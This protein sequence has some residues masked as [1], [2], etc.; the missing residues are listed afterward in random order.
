MS[1][2]VEDKINKFL[3]DDDAKEYRFAP[4]DQIHR[5][6]MY[7]KDSVTETVG[8]IISALFFF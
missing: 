5:S 8:E 7:I 1:P 4:M 2:Q 6:I 3:Q